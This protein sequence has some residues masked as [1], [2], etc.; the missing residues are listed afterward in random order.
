M[1]PSPGKVEKCI[2][3]N[4]PWLK[5]ACKVCPRR[6]VKGSKYVGYLLQLH[7]LKEGGY[8]FVA[9]DLSVEV[10]SDLGQVTQ[11]FEAKKAER[12]FA[13]CPFFSYH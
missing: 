13:R 7:Q 4:G 8:P 6:T 2:K 11:F 3:E 1:C 10:W 5:S 12:G 9:N